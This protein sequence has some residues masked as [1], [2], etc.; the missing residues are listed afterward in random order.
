MNPL[1]KLQDITEASEGRQLKNLVTIEKRYGSKCFITE[2]GLVM[3]EGESSEPVTLHHICKY[4]HLP[5][6]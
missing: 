1:K 6:K 3:G 4:A 2:I 5:G